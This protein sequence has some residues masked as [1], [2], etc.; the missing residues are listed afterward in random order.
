V[1]EGRINGREAS[2]KDW[3]IQIVSMA[4]VKSYAASLAAGHLGSSHILA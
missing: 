4:A 2:R 3:A 1:G